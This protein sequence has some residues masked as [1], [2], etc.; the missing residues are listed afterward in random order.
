MFACL[1]PFNNDTS[2]MAVHGAPSCCSNRISFNATILPVQAEIVG[3]SDAVS[4]KN[5]SKDL[6]ERRFQPRTV[7]GADAF[8]N[9]SISSF[10]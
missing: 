7:D 2:R 1:S 5:K 10:T 6:Q 8:I 3:G 9:R 4:G